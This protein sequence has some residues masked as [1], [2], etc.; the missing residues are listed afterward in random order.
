M[1][2][3]FLT[4]PHG[5][6]S[7]G[8]IVGDA[9]FEDDPCGGQGIPGS[10]YGWV[11]NRDGSVVLFQINGQNTRARGISDAGFIT[12]A[13]ND[14]LTGGIKGFVTKAPKTNCQPISIASDDLLQP[15]GAF[16]VF[17]EGITNSGDVVGLFFDDSGHHG[18]IATTQ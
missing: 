14:P 6:N 17:P 15:A 7:T 1:V 3:S 18:F 9:R 5:I 8:V 16:A 12:G 2:P 13:V 10:R 4:I 11:R